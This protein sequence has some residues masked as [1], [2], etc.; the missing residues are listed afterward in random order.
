MA[1]EDSQNMDLEIMDYT[2]KSVV[3]YG[4]TKIWKEN[5][6]ALGG[7]FNPNLKR[8]EG[9]NTVRFS[10]WVYSRS[11]AELLEIFVAESRSGIVTPLGE[12]PEEK[13][14][15]ASPP[16]KKASVPKNMVSVN[17]QVQKPTKIAHIVFASGKREEY[18]VEVIRDDKC[19]LVKADGTRLPIAIVWNVWLCLAYHETPHDIVFK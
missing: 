12:T 7:R 4:N 17:Y 9:E 11:K 10:G 15:K 13:T 3:I 2:D 18:D 5:L 8:T 16:A 1:A 19:F 14:E 6:K